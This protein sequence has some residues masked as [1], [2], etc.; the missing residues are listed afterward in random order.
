M[1][2]GP[3]FHTPLREGDVVPEGGTPTP[4]C[5]S[6][7]KFKFLS[8]SARGRLWLAAAVYYRSFPLSSDLAKVAFTC[9]TCGLCDQL[10][11]LAKVPVFRSLREEI[12][13]H[14]LKQAGVRTVDENIR[15][16]NNPFGM[17]VGQ[18]TDWA[19]NLAFSESSDILYFAGC[20]AS[21]AHPEVARATVNILNAAGLDVAYLAEKEVCCGNH[22]LWSGDVKGAKARG[23]ALL[24]TIEKSGSRIVVFSC[25]HCLR[26]FKIDYE[27][28]FGALPFK[29]KHISEVVANMISEGKLDLKTGSIRKATYHDPCTLGRHLGV[30]EEPREII[31]GIP[32]LEFVEMGRRRQWSWCCGSGG[33]VVLHAFPDFARWVARD[34]LGEAKGVADILVTS[35]AQCKAHLQDVAKRE[36]IDIRIQDLPEIIADAVEV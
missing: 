18:R 29:T 4:R 10:C 3:G 11:F 23:A 36:R 14:G 27:E 26:T 20:Y 5:P 21:Y 9:T 8:F 12:A 34:R 15:R 25:P 7:A 17:E 35:C 1:C 32:N 19:R 24:R 16:F 2:F 6:Y 31:K 28:M 30:Y 22:L 33:S 13:E